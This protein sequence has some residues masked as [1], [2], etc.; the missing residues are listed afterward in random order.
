ML[1]PLSGYLLLAEKLLSANGQRFSR[2]WNFGP[3]NCSAIT[4][5]AVAKTLAALWGNNATCELH[6]LHSNLHEAHFLKLDSTDA[7]NILHW[8]ARLPLTQ[9]LE[10]TVTWYKMAARG[11]D[12]L[13]IM[14]DQI[15][16]YMA[17]KCYD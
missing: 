7:R 13:K 16:T 2:A 6:S 17:E 10:Q 3:D 5:G 1:E 14:H 8:G 9:A 12:M 4:V 15:N 11:A